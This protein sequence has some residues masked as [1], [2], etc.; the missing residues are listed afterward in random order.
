MMSIR[1][2]ED[3]GLTGGVSGTYGLG[4]RELAPSNCH[5]VECATAGG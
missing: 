3:V 5:D 1:L 4:R 2:L